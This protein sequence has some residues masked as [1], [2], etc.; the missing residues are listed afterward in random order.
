MDYAK[1]GRTGLDISRLCLGCMTYGSPDKGTHPWSVG[2]AESRYT[3]ST[4]YS[5]M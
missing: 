4:G 2:E 5:L 3:R 1:L